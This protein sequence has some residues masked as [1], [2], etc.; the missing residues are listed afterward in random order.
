MNK[1]KAQKAIKKLLAYTP[2][3]L[4]E[5]VNFYGVDEEELKEDEQAPFF[6]EAYLYNLV[7]KD[8]ARTLLYCLSEICKYLDIDMRDIQVKEQNE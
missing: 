4:P 1:I 2:G 3:H 8:E 7:G 6:S 5:G